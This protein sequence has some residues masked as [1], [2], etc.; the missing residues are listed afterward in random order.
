MIED[1]R[2][3]SDAQSD[4]TIRGTTETAGTPALR[5]VSNERKRTWIRLALLLVIGALIFFPALR[6]P[7][8]LDDYLHASMIDGT[9][10]GKRGVFDLYDFINAAD[11]PVLAERGMITWWSDPNLEIRFFRPLA[12]ALRWGDHLVFGRNTLLLHLHSFAWWFAAVLGARSLFV[13]AM[14]A[15]AAAV[16]TFIFALAPCHVMPLAWLANREVFMSLAFGTFALS[17]YHRFRERRSWSQAG[18]ATLLFA[19]AL[20]SGEYALSF[21]GFVLAIEIGIRGEG[22]VRR[23]LGMLPFALPT[24]LYMA[25]RSVLGYGSRGSGY[26]TDPL[27]DPVLF[28]STAPRRFVTLLANG[29]LSLDYESIDSTTSKWWLVVLVVFVTPLIVVPLRR[30]LAEL[31]EARRRWFWFFVI[32]SL[33]ALVPV[34]AVSPTPRVLGTSMLGVAP[35]VAMVLD[36]AWFVSADR[37][38]DRSV[39]AQ[40][41]GFAAVLM[42]FMHL[43]HGPGASWLSALRIHDHAQQFVDHAKSL[44]ERLQTPANAEIIVLRAVVNSFYM[45][46]VLDPEGRLP[47][48]WRILSQ[49]G[50]AL[51]LRRGPR[52]LDIVVRHEDRIYSS[53]PDHLFRQDHKSFKVGDVHTMPGV[54]M[55]ILAVGPA[56]PR[57][58]RY[59]FDHELESSSL[60][61]LAENNDGFSIEEPLKIGFGKPFDL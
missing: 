48:R 12:S 42:G 57:I 18:L 23:G 20:L 11:R 45:P 13:R 16:A 46:F 37:P 29:W 43:V 21:A 35:L 47:V 8:L 53:G 26:Y 32:G 44:R 1:A 15:R 40:L 50:H 39:M 61:W 9:F 30:T 56:G 25:V 24:L 5:H 27:R 49:T 2:S 33:L 3:A 52:T 31:D 54:R 7:F 17:V 38:A 10:P 41:S 19:L 4:A 60:I 6:S 55:T 34:M 58:V 36:H 51:V 59:D 28:L 14:S 22:I